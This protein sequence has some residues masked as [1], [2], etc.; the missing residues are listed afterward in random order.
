MLEEKIFCEIN[1]GTSEE[2]IGRGLM[3]MEEER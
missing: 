2:R 3:G 1:N